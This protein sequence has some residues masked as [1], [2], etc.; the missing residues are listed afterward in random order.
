MTR[1][2]RDGAP[3]VAVDAIGGRAAAR[4]RSGRGGRNDE[5]DN[6]ARG[7]DEVLKPKASGVRDAIEEQ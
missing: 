1:E 5:G 3:V 2:V 6:R 7:Q 4:A